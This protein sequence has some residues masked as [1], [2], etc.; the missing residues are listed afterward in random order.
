[1]LI[2]DSSCS[3]IGSSSTTKSGASG[4]IDPQELNPKTARIANKKMIRTAEKDLVS[5]KIIASKINYI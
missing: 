2:D 4:A 3:G 1:M 5:C